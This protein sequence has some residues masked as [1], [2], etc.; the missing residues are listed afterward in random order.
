MNGLNPSDQ[1]FSNNSLATN[2]LGGGG[3][4]CDYE[5]M[6][7]FDPSKFPQNFNHNDITGLTT[8]GL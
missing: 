6:E 5:D 8:H 1:N 4:L 3:Q 2:G 7:Q